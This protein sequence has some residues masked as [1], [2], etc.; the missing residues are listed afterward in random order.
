MLPVS[1]AEEMLIDQISGLFIE[2]RIY[3]KQQV[4]RLICEVLAS[5]IA[6]A[7]ARYSVEILI[8]GPVRQEVEH[9]YSYAAEVVSIS[10]IHSLMVE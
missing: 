10:F 6:E 2:S 8:V 5:E 1:A 4:L 7:G 9:L 3:L